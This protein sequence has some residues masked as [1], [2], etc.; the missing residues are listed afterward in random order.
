MA[1]QVRS[2]FLCYSLSL[3]PDDMIS[4]MSYELHMTVGEVYP[5]RPDVT[6]SHTLGISGQ[7]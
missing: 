2:L 1:L 3:K 5:G 6:A 7:M 4:C